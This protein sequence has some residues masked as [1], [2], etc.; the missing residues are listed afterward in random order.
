ML[1]SM[2]HLGA[3]EVSMVPELSLNECKCVAQIVDGENGVLFPVGDDMKLSEAIVRVLK[4][5]SKGAIAVSGQSKARNMF[6]SNV[7]LRFGELLESI[8]EFPSETALP[9]PLDE[10]VKRLEWRWRWDLL[11]PANSPFQSRMAEQRVEEDDMGSGI[12]KVLEDEWI[13]RSAE[14][15]NSSEI[16]DRQNYTEIVGPHTYRADLQLPSTFDIHEAKATDKDVV[17]EKTEREEVHLFQFLK[18]INL[19]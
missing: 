9:R 4:D 1:N 5:E 19:K 18:N 2:C 15:Q 12:V 10:A 6:A 3:L 7:S 11:F 13:L 14:A 17:A 16:G 8:L